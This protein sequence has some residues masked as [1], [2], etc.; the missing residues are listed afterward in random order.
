MFPRPFRLPCLLLLGLTCGSTLAASTAR[1]ADVILRTSLG[2]IPVELFEEDAPETVANFLGYVRSGAYDDTLV[3]RSVRNFVIQSGGFKLFD[4]QI[5][6]APEGEP[7]TNEPGRSNLRGTIAMAKL[8]DDPDSATNQWFIN[9][10]DNP[11]L[12]T[13]NEGF[14][15]FGRVTGDGMAVVDAINDLPTWNFGA[16]FTQLPLVDFDPTGV[17]EVANLVLMDVDEVVDFPITAGLNDAWFEPSTSGQGMF[18]TVY[19]DTGPGGQVF[20]S[21]FTYDV[22]RPGEDVVSAF[23]DPGHRWMTAI[24]SFEGNRAVLDLTLTSGGV[25]DAVNPPAQN[26]PEPSG[27][28]TVRFTDCD[29]ALV[30]WDIPGP[31]PNGGL[32]GTAVMERV[33]KDNLALCEALVAAAAA[34]DANEAP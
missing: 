25:F 24:G 30:N 19:P 23:G 33:S 20:L 31:G 14:T 5:N 2:D 18:V 12:N 7:V 9:V 28:L 34:D 16:P 6:L 15:V 4:R 29:T 13:Q 10:E 32:N 1:A 17:L 3:H 27:T 22:E 8:A 21:W 11:D 26:D